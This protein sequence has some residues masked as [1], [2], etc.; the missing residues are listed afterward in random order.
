MKRVLLGLGASIGDRL[1]SL[2]L[3][4]KMLSLDEK[5]ELLTYSSVYETPPMGRASHLFLNIVIVIKTSRSPR[6]ILDLCKRIEHHLG[7]RHSPRWSDRVLDIDILDYEGVIK[8]TGKQNGIDFLKGYYTLPLIF[9]LSNSTKSEKKQITKFL[10]N[11]NSKKDFKT[12][13]N[14]VITNRSGIR[15]DVVFEGTVE[16]YFD[17]SQVVGTGTA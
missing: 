1:D 10:I 14:F 6:G 5:I 9:A 15:T 8:Q 4:V 17:P 7:R 3:A 16:H 11:D 2:K 13:Q 12:I